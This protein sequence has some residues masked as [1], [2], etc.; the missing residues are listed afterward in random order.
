LTAAS[1]ELE[2]EVGFGAVFLANLRAVLGGLRAVLVAELELGLFSG[3]GAVLVAE[4][5]LGLLI[6]GL[7]AVLLA[8]LRV[9]SGTSNAL[10]TS[11]AA[12]S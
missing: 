10:A 11:L 4:L 1:L 5:A 8:N 12:A 6:S 7:R 2:L 9:S 3:L